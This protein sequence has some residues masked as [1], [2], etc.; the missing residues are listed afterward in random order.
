MRVLIL[1]QAAPPDGFEQ[2]A[3]GDHMQI[4]I[5]RGPGDPADM[6]SDESRAAAEG[7]VCSSAQHDIG[8]PDLYPQCRVV[9]RM[10]VGFDNVDAAAWG[11]RGVPVCNVPDY[12]TSEVA[13]HAIAL[14]LALTRGTGFYHERVARD[15]VEGWTWRG[16]P[17]MRRLRDATFGVVGLGRIGLA[18]ALRARAFGMALAFYDPYAPNGLEIAV[19]ARRCQSLDEL[20]ASSDVVSLHAPLSGETR[21]LIGARALAAAKPGLILVNT[22]R[23]PMVDL[24]ALYEALRQ[25]QIG[26]AALDVLP[27]EPPDPAHP[28]LRALRAREP[29]LEGRL[30]VTPHAAFYSPASLPDMRRKALEVVLHY[31]RDGRLT[32]C[33]NAAVLKAPLR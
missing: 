22:A 33:V 10:G 23:G 27:D 18:A 12:G 14:M 13:D 15:P 17:L 7:I 21:G 31:L 16:A 26:G 1:N 32:N 8:S 20:M 2:A 29:W 30:V 5:H 25:G 4:E 6:P 3:F 19:G 9:V 24:D 11:A 28:L